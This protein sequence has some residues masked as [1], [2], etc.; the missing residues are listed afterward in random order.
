MKKIFFPIYENNSPGF[1]LNMKKISVFGENFLL[2][3][4][5]LDINLRTRVK[6]TLY[7]P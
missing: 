1:S 2:I 6:I 5:I 4:H 3:F 7:F